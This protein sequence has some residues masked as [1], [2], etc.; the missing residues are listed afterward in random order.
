LDESLGKDEQ[1]RKRSKSSYSLIKRGT[2]TDSSG[3]PRRQNS[4]ERNI[5]K[6]SL[7]KKRTGGKKLNSARSKWMK[8]K[9]NVMG[10]MMAVNRQPAPTFDS[11]IRFCKLSAAVRHGKHKKRG[12]HNCLLATGGKDGAVLIWEIPML[13]KKTARM[14]KK[15]MME[16]VSILY[17]FPIQSWC[18]CMCFSEDASFFGH[19]TVNGRLRLHETSNG[20]QFQVFQPIDLGGPNVQDDGGTASKKKDGA[21]NALASAGSKITKNNNASKGLGGAQNNQAR[22]A[23]CT[24]LVDDDA[25]HDAASYD[26][27]LVIYVLEQRIEGKRWA[28]HVVVRDVISAAILHMYCVNTAQS[29]LA[30][31][32]SPTRVI[33]AARPTRVR[34][35]DL[36]MHVHDLDAG[37]VWESIRHGDGAESKTAITACCL[38]ED[39]EYLAIA[40][41]T[42]K[43]TV[44]STEEVSA[45]VAFSQDAKV[46][47]VVFT[48]DGKFLVTGG[49]GKKNGRKLT[50]LL[51][52]RSVSNGKTP[53]SS[54]SSK[55]DSDMM[56][57]NEW[58]GMG[59]GGLIWDAQHDGPVTDAKFNE[60][61]EWLAVADGAEAS[62][63]KLRIYKAEDG[64][65]LRQLPFNGSALQCDVQRYSL[66]NEPIIAAVG[67]R[68]LIN[69]WSAT[70]FENITSRLDRHDDDHQHH[71][72]VVNFSPC[73]QYFAT[74]DAEG[75]VILREFVSHT[76]TSMD[77]TKMGTASELEIRSVPY[78]WQCSGP[79]SGLFF[80]DDGHKHTIMVFCYWDG[81]DEAFRTRF[82]QVI[83]PMYPDHEWWGA[84][85]A[86]SGG[87]TSVN[88]KSRCGVIV[89][90][91]LVDGR[92][93]LMNL[94]DT[95]PLPSE[96]PMTGKDCGAWI[97]HSPYLVHRQ[98]RSR[99]GETILHML[100]GLRDTAPLQ[101]YIKGA[102]KIAPII[103]DSGRT[104][105]DVAMDNNDYAKVRLLLRGYIEWSTTGLLGLKKPLKQMA[106]QY[107]NL[108]TEFLKKCTKSVDCP[109][110]RMKVKGP[111]VSHGNTLNGPWTGTEK[112]GKVLRPVDAMVVGFSGF[113]D[114]DGPY[115]AIV[116][117][118]ELPAF[119]T[120]SLRR[121][122]HFKWQQV[123]TT[124][125]RPCFSSC[126]NI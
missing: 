45:L 84:A 78:K 122:I 21:V 6:R 59:E 76:R 18:T 12:E 87:R 52:M 70:T 77:G 47:T 99:K 34:G 91:S 79:I 56:G 48:P 103:D 54:P 85:V 110:K 32:A 28:V 111:I 19:G 75:Q 4:T 2:S 13:S 123:S 68:G 50:G 82:I 1:R 109:F 124:I 39:G 100:C 118:G 20:A 86:A 62:T 93:T 8:A 57:S 112:N 65:I 9:K 117:H 26:D 80:I 89:V 105:L 113:M 102:G 72:T 41:A 38:S 115:E 98:D 36:L 67:E 121:V 7:S 116:E 55:S 120:E 97:Q 5:I 108:I 114:S 3:G 16:A 17:R 83:G 33:V 29:S 14:D 25:P 27:D 64:T 63:N 101:S 96:M 95:V 37:M 66:N 81:E 22:V 69:L 73:G 106:K 31:W 94:T 43:V 24:L 46:Q 107:P 126:Q 125:I 42:T 104:P 61:G 58:G 11:S 10:V 40:D 71:C 119:D 49:N 30:L 88:M 53:V 44:Y 51:V 35:R 60:G 90:E 15:N 23:Q 74:G 92:I